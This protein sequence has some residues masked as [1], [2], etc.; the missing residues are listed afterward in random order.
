MGQAELPGISPASS[1]CSATSA[2]TAEV[3]AGLPALAAPLGLVWKQKCRVHATLFPCLLGAPSAGLRRW[4]HHY[5]ARPQ[6]HGW[7]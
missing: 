3:G 7:C 1:G 5:E 6:W 2:V 4:V